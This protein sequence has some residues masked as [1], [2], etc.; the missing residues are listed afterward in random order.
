MT[1]KENT[2]TQKELIDKQREIVSAAQATAAAHPDLPTPAAAL[3]PHS[4]TLRALVR[5]THP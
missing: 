5:A 3:A 4:E 1:Q 2:M